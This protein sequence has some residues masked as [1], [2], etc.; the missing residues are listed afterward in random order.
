MKP[1]S[2][3]LVQGLLGNTMHLPSQ[4][5]TAAQRVPHLSPAHVHLSLHCKFTGQDSSV[6]STLYPLQLAQE[7]DIPLQQGRTE[8]LCQPC[9]MD[10]ES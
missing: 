7:P 9:V 5:L 6:L 3:E 1:Q 8:D 4:C 10:G 2:S